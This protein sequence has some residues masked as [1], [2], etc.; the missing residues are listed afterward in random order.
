MEGGEVR[1]AEVAMEVGVVEEWEVTTRGREVSPPE[2]AEVVV[3]A[4]AAL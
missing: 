1:T 4:E 2:E 3:E